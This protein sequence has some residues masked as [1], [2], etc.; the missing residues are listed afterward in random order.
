M[1]RLTS[2]QPFPSLDVPAI[3]GGTMSLPGDRGSWCP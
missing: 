1:S 3:G 2:G